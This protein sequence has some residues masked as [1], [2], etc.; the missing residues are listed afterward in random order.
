M[1]LSR[2]K[3][4]ELIELV[5]ETNS[6]LKYQ[7]NDVRGMT[8]T[9]EIIPTKANVK[10]T[11]LSK[12]LVVHPNEFIFNPRTHGKKIGFG[13][14]NSNKAFLIS[15]NNI[16]F[17]LS[18]YGRKLAL[19]K[20]LFLHFN[21]SEWDR[22]ACFSSW[23]SSTEVFSWNA[24]CDMDIDLPPLAIQQ[25]YVDV[26]NAMVANQKAYERGLEDLKLTC[27][28][29]IEDLRRRIPCEAIGPYIERHDVRNGQNGTKNV[30]GVSTTKEFREP[31]SKVNRNDLANYKV[32]KPRQISFVQTTHNEKVF[33]NAFNNTD[34]DIVVT[35][36]NEVF[37][38]NENKLLPE[39]LVMFFNRTEFDRYARYHSWGSARET[40][41]WDDLIKVEIPIADINIQKSIVDIYTVYKERKSINEKLKAQIKAICPILIKG[42]IEEGRNTKEA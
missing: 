24:L 17:S 8:I 25:K 28:A 2:Y 9:K 33:C 37:S 6:D 35:S 42:S 16:A 29:Y 10:N 40:F 32:V 38:T 12:F 23:G 30:M 36:V 4:G 34:K 22:A 19:P 39:Y 15:W 1:G 18:E 26:Y 13:Y 3:L 5:T 20:Y 27:D 7:E 14:N 41:T 31:T 21:R 11:D